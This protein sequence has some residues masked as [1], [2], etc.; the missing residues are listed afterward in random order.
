M[1]VP[2]GLWFG[3]GGLALGKGV[4][5][6]MSGTQGVLG[7]CSMGVRDQALVG[8]GHLVGRDG[9]RKEASEWQL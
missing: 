8:S 1:A 5:R 7:N 4:G 2:A 3:V 6:R 9:R